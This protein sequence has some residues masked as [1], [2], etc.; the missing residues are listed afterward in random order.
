[1]RCAHCKDSGPA[2]TVAHVRACSQSEQ[3]IR[4]IGREAPAPVAVAVKVPTLAERVSTDFDLIEGVYLKDGEYYKVQGNLAGTAFY[5][6]RWAG[7]TDDSEWAYEGRK[8]LHFL[9]ED[10]RISAEDAARFGQV[11]GICVFCSRKLTDERSITVGYGP[12]CA[13]REGLPWG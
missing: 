1:M 9:T 6:K 10:D 8:P 7:S 3:A 13:D 2:V 11:T 5:A 12:V 4:S